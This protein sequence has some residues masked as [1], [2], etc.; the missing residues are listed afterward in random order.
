M[1]DLTFQPEDGKRLPCRDGEDRTEY[2]EPASG[3]RLRVSRSGART[4]LV[5]FWSPVAKTTRRLKL[6]DGARMPLSK[7]RAG[8]RAALHS[9]EQERRDPH[10][11][12]VVA[13]EREREARRRRAEE[14]EGEARDRARR[15]IGFGK[16]CEQY[17]HERATK[18]SGRFARRARRNTLN[19]WRSMLE[20]H[21][22]PVIGDRPPEDI[23]RADFRRT[24]ERAVE[25]GGPSMGPRVRDFLTGIWHWIEQRSEELG[26]RMPAASPLVG[27]PKVGMVKGERERWLVPAELWRF[28]RATEPEGLPG[29]ALR[30][31]VL[32]AARVSEATELVRSELDLGTRTWVLPAARH[33]AVRDRVTPLSPQALALLARCPKIEGEERVFGRFDLE[34][35]INRVR[36][37]MGGEAWESRDLRRTAATLLAGL[38]VDESII[39]RILGHARPDKSVPKIT[40]VYVRW[41]HRE[42]VREALDRLGAW[43]EDTVTRT[44]EPGDVVSIEARR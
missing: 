18:A 27:L 44:T 7:A 25:N 13:R 4:W 14:R 41:D 39:S 40:G 21:V 31:M 34:P 36:E 24:L 17:I 6:G 42:R 30:F 43:L 20:K 10:A 1:A 8:A 38:G 15:R 2:H 12:R 11:E 16:L 37:R 35:V 28:W 9:V 19:N 23:T 32:T 29:E 22:A 26:V 33:K 5:A 3:L